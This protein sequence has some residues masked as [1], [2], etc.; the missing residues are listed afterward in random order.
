MFRFGVFVW[1]G[2]T[3]VGFA[4]WLGYL[5]LLVFWVAVAFVLWFTVLGWFG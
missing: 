4:W 3:Q 2:L 5:L 1:C